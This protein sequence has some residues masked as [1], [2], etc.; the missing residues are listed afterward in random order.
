MY[1]RRDTAEK[2]SSG[3]YK[4]VGETLAEAQ[5]REVFLG[6]PRNG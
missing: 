1:R 6:K 5:L 3:E 2:I 4:K